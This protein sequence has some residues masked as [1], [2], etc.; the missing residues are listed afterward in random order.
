MTI[1]VP[2]GSEGGPEISPK[3]VDVLRNRLERVVKRI[4]ACDDS[5]K[6]DPDPIVC[7]IRGRSMETIDAF[8]GKFSNREEPDSYEQRDRAIADLLGEHAELSPLLANLSDADTATLMVYLI[9]VHNDLPKNTPP[10]FSEFILKLMRNLI[11]MR[12]LD[13]E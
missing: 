11:S 6:K 7:D 10:T 13:I 8:E 12:T 5:L 1:A 3:K 4:R 2:S 9:S